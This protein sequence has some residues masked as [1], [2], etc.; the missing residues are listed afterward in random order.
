MLV[1]SM[2]SLKLTLT[3]M[4]SLSNLEIKLIRNS[5]MT[6]MA[7]IIL[8]TLQKIPKNANLWAIYR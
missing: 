1:Q 5:S 2:I 3:I 6:V 8:N 4:I 7:E